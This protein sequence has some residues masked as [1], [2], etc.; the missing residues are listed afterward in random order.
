MECRQCICHVHLHNTQLPCTCAQPLGPDSQRIWSQQIGQQWLALEG[1]VLHLR[2]ILTA[3][4][5]QDEQRNTL[6]WNGEVFGGLDR[7]GLTDNDTAG[8]LAAL[9]ADSS[10]RHVLA[11]LARLRGPWAMVFYQPNRQRLWFGRDHFGRRSLVWRGPIVDE[12]DV[13]LVIA[14]VAG[15]GEGW[16]E[17]PA[18]GVYCLDLSLSTPALGVGSDNTDLSTMGVHQYK[19]G[20]LELPSPIA[21]GFNRNVPDTVLVAELRAQQ[22]VQSA[23]GNPYWD[24]VTRVLSVLQHSVARRVLPQALDAGQ[25]AGNRPPI[26]LLFSGGLDCMVLA[27]LVHAILPPNEPVA[28]YNVAFENHRVQRANGGKPYE[29]CPDRVSGR[30][31]VAEL[32]AVFPRPWSFVAVDVPRVE[33]DLAREAV[34]R[35]VAPLASVMDM[36]IG[37]ALWFAARCAG[38][39]G[40]R[41]LL[42]GMGADEQ[43]GGYSRH[44]SAFARG[45]WP[46]LAAELEL[47]VGRISARN[48]GRDDR[49]LSDHGCE[50][51]FPFLDEE[52]VAYV[53]SLPIHYKVCPTNRAC[54]L[55]AHQESSTTGQEVE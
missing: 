40:H 14:S 7:L 54:F 13:S 52:L 19:W 3:Q 22:E 21:D 23:E 9:G 6:L 35:A 34:Q 48:L 33:L 10:E 36:D 5:A 46:A 29:S 4:P 16:R 27:G 2:G 17:L 18:D 53:N 32:V 31:G 1:H 51:R 49:C 38:V 44:R 47:D 37:S 12:P 15:D 20:S 50:A 26:A 11:V 8:L 55:A 24:A 30:R 25:V 39:A 41:V 28:L 42:V 45:D 43:F